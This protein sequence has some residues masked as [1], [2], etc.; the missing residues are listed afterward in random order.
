MGHDVDMDEYL[1]K[2]LNY[3]LIALR[4]FYNEYL[5]KLGPLKNLD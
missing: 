4:A 2:D 3:T 1:P 5:I